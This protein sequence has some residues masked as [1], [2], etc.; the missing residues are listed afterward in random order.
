[1]ANTNKPQ[2]LTPVQY[3]GGAD[4]D[5]KGRLYYIDSTD[6]NAYYPGD[7]V[8]LQNGLD[9]EHGLPTIGVVTAGSDP[10]LGVILAIGAS[11]STTW[12]M[13]GGPF[14]DPTNL[15]MTYAPATKTKNYFALVADDPN[16]IFMIQEGGSGAALTKAACTYNA[17]LLLAA[18]A[19]GVYISGATLSNATAPTTTA[20][21]QLKIMG[22][23][24]ILDN[25]AWN[26]FGAYA[27]WLVLINN[28]VY[29][30]STGTAGI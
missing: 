9:A 21:Y 24:Q 17:I 1:M 25:G 19:T 18:P 12:S 7:A 4:W 22:L 10:I 20:T 26:T 23:A 2:G 5:G 13:Q 14:I 8:Y 28:H 15:S 29:G 6:P 3:L 16:I 11:P 30:H 27:K